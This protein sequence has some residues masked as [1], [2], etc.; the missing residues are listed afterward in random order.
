MKKITI[1]PP[2]GGLS[3]FGVTSPFSHSHFGEQKISPNEF[4]D[5]INDDSNA[6]KD[7]HFI[8][9]SLGRPGFGKLI[10]KTNYPSLS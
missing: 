8:P 7:A 3:H 5:I 4:I 10:I 2:N 1:I 6:I 9:P